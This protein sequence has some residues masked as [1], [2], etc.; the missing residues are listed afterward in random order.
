MYLFIFFYHFGLFFGDGSSSI[1]KDWNLTIIAIT[2]FSE[3]SINS[4]SSPFKSNIVY[5]CKYLSFRIETSIGYHSRSFDYFYE[6]QFVEWSFAEN[7][8]VKR[9]LCELFIWL[10]KKGEENSKRRLTVCSRIS[11]NYERYGRFFEAVDLPYFSPEID[12]HRRETRQRSLIFHRGNRFYRGLPRLAQSDSWA[13]HRNSWRYRTVSKGRIATKRKKNQKYIRSCFTNKNC[14]NVSQY[15]YLPYYQ[16]RVNIGV[17]KYLNSKGKKKVFTNA[18]PFDVWTNFV[19]MKRRFVKCTG[20]ANH[21]NINNLVCVVK[22]YTTLG[23][24]IGVVFFGVVR[25]GFWTLI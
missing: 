5:D 6:F 10:L 22:A 7:R 2:R 13:Q 16:F 1:L 3:Y 18:L 23:V 20:S 12:P 14:R 19:Q 15:R 4:T 17:F 9:L 24:A 25:G 8:H 21:Y 11:L